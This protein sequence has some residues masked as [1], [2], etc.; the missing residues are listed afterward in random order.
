MAQNP[1]ASPRPARPHPLAGAST[2]IGWRSTDLPQ[3]T[4]AAAILPPTPVTRPVAPAT[5]L[6][7]VVSP[8]ASPVE[9]PAREPTQP[10]FPV[11]ERPARRRRPDALHRVATVRGV[12]SDP[13][14]MSS[15]VRIID[16]RVEPL[17]PPAPPVSSPAVAPV[18]PVPPARVDARAAA[19]RL[20]LVSSM[21]SIHSVAPLP[22]TTRSVPAGVFVA[23]ALVTGVCAYS[24]VQHLM[25]LVVG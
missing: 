7:A 24:L 15:T 9:P 12:P 19:P 22:A 11:V 10:E 16:S 5:M 3:P 4:P 13:A 1:S 17:A 6:S 21:P 8:A 14:L 2:L 20:V 25:L 18:A 23:A